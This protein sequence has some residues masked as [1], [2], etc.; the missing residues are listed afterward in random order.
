MSLNVAFVKYSQSTT[1]F[2][3]GYGQGWDMIV[4][5]TEFI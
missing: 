1:T 2:G 3:K 4:M 5:V